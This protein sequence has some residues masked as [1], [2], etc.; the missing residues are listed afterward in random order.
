MVQLLVGAGA[1]ASE[2]GSQ[3]P[4]THTQSYAGWTLVH[5]LEGGG[6][7]GSADAG[8]SDGGNQSP[9]THTQSDAGCGEVQLLEGGGGAGAGAGAGAGDTMPGGSQLP[10]TQTQS[11]AGCG[12]VQLLVGGGGGGGVGVPPPEPVCPAG[13]PPVDVVP[14]MK[15]TAD[16]V[17]WLNATFQVGDTVLVE[18]RTFLARTPGPMAVIADVRTP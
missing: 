16:C 9:L 14:A 15:F 6:G 5:V 7:G 8:A 10:F 1:G 13:P 2:G 17:L 4:F 12:E 3:L 18:T 11:E